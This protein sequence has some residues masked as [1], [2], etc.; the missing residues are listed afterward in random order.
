MLLAHFL[1]RS[2][3]QKKEIKTHKFF[4]GEKIE[5]KIHKASFFFF[6]CQLALIM[7]CKKTFFC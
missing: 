4:M 3:K 2:E 6:E 1:Q 5:E 7:A